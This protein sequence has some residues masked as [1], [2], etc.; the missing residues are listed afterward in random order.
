MPNCELPSSRFIHFP[1]TGGWFCHHVFQSLGLPITVSDVTIHGGHIS[2]EKFGNQSKPAFGF[3]RNPINWY[4]SFFNWLVDI[5]W[6]FY[7]KM[8]VSTLDEFVD[9]IFTENYDIKP[10]SQMFHNQLHGVELIGMYENLQHDLA[11]ILNHVGEQ[12][13][14][15]AVLTCKSRVNVSHNNCK[16]EKR[17]MKKVFERDHA[18]FRRFYNGS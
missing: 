7:P 13:N 10:M 1:K 3:V 11:R 12:F 8:R 5:N 17:T 9:L 18:V 6:H 2:A 4:E 15:A 14:E 16:M